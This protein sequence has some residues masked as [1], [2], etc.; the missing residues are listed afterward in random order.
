MLGLSIYLAHPPLSGQLELDCVG[1][2]VD[3]REQRLEP[4]AHRRTV[5]I[6]LEADAALEQA[7]LLVR[8]RLRLRLRVRV[9]ARVRA[10]WLGLG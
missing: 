9:R 6:Q 2:L 5:L 10:S 3:R 1:A 7:V 8:A 4:R